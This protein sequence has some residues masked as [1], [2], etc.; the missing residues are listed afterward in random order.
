[1]LYPGYKRTKNKSILT[2]KLGNIADAVEMFERALE[3]AKMIGDSKAEKG[4]QRA[5]EDTSAKLIANMKNNSRP[6]SSSESRPITADQSQKNDEAEDVADEVESNAEKDE[7]ADKYEESVTQD[8]DNDVEDNTDDQNTQDDQND[9]RNAE[10]V[11]DDAPEE[12]PEE[13]E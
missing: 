4:I 8:A 10:V 12:V 6:E 5:L 9:Q 1:M 7:D 2:V 11:T 3:I 13:E